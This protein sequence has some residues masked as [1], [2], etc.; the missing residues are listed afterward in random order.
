MLRITSIILID[1]SDYRF[2]VEKGED[3][4]NLQIIANDKIVRYEG[5][6]GVTEINLNSFKRWTYKIDEEYYKAR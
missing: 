3:V 2:E 5:K 1:N 4:K 6:D